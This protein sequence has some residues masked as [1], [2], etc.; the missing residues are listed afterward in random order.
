[1]PLLDGPALVA[2]SFCL[3]EVS[4]TFYEALAICD[5]VGMT[6]LC[7][8]P[9]PDLDDVAAGL[10]AT[11]VE[12][13]NPLLNEKAEPWFDLDVGALLVKLDGWTPEQTRA[14][15]EAAA[16]YGML[17]GGFVTEGQRL[18]VVGLHRDDEEDY[19]DDVVVNGTHVLAGALQQ[20]VTEYPTD[21]DTAPLSR[22]SLTDPAGN[23][24]ANIPLQPGHL[25]WLTR[26]ISDEMASCRNAHSDGTGH[27]GHCRG[28]GRA[29]GTG[30]AALLDE[31]P[32]DDGS[33]P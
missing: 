2:R 29:G 12:V 21:A 3:R 17:P 15:V 31:P 4:L 16:Q 25:P 30:G 7:A 23:A 5:V 13:G 27:C 28:T 22:L 19:D 18:A 8:D 32:A 1:M 26:L 11:F 9:T 6:Y 14:V 24:T 10:H 20:L 33:R